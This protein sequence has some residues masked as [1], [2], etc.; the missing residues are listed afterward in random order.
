MVIVVA[1]FA[2]CWLP[3]HVYF[4][5]GSFNIDIY[6]QP[7]IQQV[8][9]YLCVI[10]WSLTYL[11]WLSLFFVLTGVSGHF[12]AGHEFDHV[13]PHHLLLSKPKVTGRVTP[14]NHPSPSNSALKTN[15]SL[16]STGFVLVS[17]MHSRGVP[18][19]RCQR[20]TR[21]NCSTHTP[22]ES[23]WHAATAETAHPP[24]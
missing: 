12:L 9:S 24:K 17:V 11:P 4:I 14:R 22:S 3:Y 10:H 21:W 1:T 2:L 16:I 5:L 18:S 20:R 8:S 13:Q 15:F 7:Y 23:P 19:S 6:K